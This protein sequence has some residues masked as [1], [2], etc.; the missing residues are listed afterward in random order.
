MMR[1]GG[2]NSGELRR[3]FSGQVSGGTGRRRARNSRGKARERGGGRVGDREDRFR[4][5]KKGK[6][7]GD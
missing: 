6:V 7:L 2:N 4:L 5:E 1:K 3:G